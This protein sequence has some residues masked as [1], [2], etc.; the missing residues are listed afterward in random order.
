MNENDN[1]NNVNNVAVDNERNHTNNPGNNNDNDNVDSITTHP[2][3]NS[4]LPNLS[5]I[6]SK[7][8]VNLTPKDHLTMI[9]RQLECLI[10]LWL[11]QKRACVAKLYINRIA[12]VVGQLCQMNHVN[13]MIFVRAATDDSLK[14]LVHDSSIVTNDLTTDQANGIAHSWS[15]GGTMDV[16]PCILYS[17]NKIAVLAAIIAMNAIYVK[18][19]YML[20]EVSRFCTFHPIKLPRRDEHYDRV[21]YALYHFVVDVCRR[22][23]NDVEIRQLTKM[24]VEHLD[25]STVESVSELLITELAD[26]GGVLHR[27][28]ITSPLARFIRITIDMIKNDDEFVL[29]MGEYRNFDTIRATGEK[30]FGDGMESLYRFK[31]RLVLVKRPDDCMK[32]SIKEVRNFLSTY[33]REMRAYNRAMARDGRA[34]PEY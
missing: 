10:E 14:F 25:T 24:Q 6:G 4:F 30:F 7:I 29:L 22:N 28:T 9:A 33:G 18:G 32:K 3:D 2:G 5:I 1:T 17:N 23:N 27:H 11:E 21:V 34:S 16:L 26:T 31:R 8:Y 13:R 19:T 15:G 12:D 20:A